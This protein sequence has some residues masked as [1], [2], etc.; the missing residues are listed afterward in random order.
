MLEK[1]GGLCCLDFLFQVY[2]NI[3]CVCV[4]VSLTPNGDRQLQ[5][6]LQCKDFSLLLHQRQLLANKAHLCDSSCNLSSSVIWKKSRWGLG[7]SGNCRDVEFLP[8]GALTWRWLVSGSFE[9]WHFS[10]LLEHP[11]AG[12][13]A[14][15]SPSISFSIWNFCCPLVLLKM[16]FVFTFFIHLFT[17]ENNVWKSLFLYRLSI[18]IYISKFWFIFPFSVLR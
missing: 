1:L 15:G 13:T 7:S 6:V 9:L 2:L 5:G 3:V 11:F 16:E 14:F 10:V 12:P 17:F 4:C 18:D 8:A